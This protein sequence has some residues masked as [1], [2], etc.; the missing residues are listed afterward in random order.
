MDGIGAVAQQVQRTV[1]QRP[2]FLVVQSPQAKGDTRVTKEGCCFLHDTAQ[3]VE[4]VGVELAFL[5]ISSPLQFGERRHMVEEGR[6]FCRLK[7]VGAVTVWSVQ[8]IAPVSNRRRV[9]NLPAE[10]VTH[11][12]EEQRVVRRKDHL[13][14]RRIPVRIRSR[15]RPAEELGKITGDGNRVVVV[16]RRDRVVDVEVLLP[17]IGFMPIQHPFADGHKNAPDEDVLFAA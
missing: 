17:L 9:I 13:D 3:C 7:Q 14:G 8:E 6:V 4:V 12:V 15:G 16:Q 2:V 1:E 5:R 10:L 11:H